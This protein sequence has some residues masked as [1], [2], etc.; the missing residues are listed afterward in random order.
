MGYNLGMNVLYP[1]VLY[2]PQD[3]FFAARVQDVVARLGGRVQMVEHVADL[4]EELH[5]PP[6]WVILEMGRGDQG[7]WL[8]LARL[9]RSRF[10][11]TPILA[12][13]SH[14]DVAARAAAREAGCDPVWSRSRFAKE[15]PTLAAAYLQPG[16]HTPGCEEPLPERVRE[17]LRLFNQGAYYRCHDVLEEAWREEPRACRL[18]YQGILQLGIALHHI[19]QGNGR[20]ALKMLARA[21]A[22]FDALPPRC[23]GI[24]VIALQ[25]IT[26]DLHEQ[27]LALGPHASH[28]FPVPK[29]K[30]MDDRR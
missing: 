21:A 5:P 13:G 7:D 10:P 24:D 14:V 12:F 23:Q 11:H 29:I 27:L 30:T 25:K 9:V 17:G 26:R 28:A 4:P 15:F 16:T 2:H 22:K 19:Q 20:G 18:L 6:V 3:L 1:L 8:M